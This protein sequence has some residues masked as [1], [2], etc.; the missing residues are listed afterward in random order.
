MF[1]KDADVVGCDEYTCMQQLRHKQLLT[2]RDIES[3]YVK[4]H[5]KDIE[6]IVFLVC[7][8]L[9]DLINPVRP[10]WLSGKDG[11]FIVQSMAH[12]KTQV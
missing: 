6:I 1:S 2:G 10:W 9:T 8:A 12:A 3:V 4:V 7:M 5:K 11:C